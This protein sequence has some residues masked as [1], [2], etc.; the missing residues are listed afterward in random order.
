MKEL[1]PEYERELSISGA[2]PR[3]KVIFELVDGPFSG[4][5]SVEAGR[6]EL[7]INLLVSH[8]LLKHSSGF[9][10]KFL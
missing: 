8:D 10:V 3:Y 1:I 4:V 2:E 6:D 5:M 7:I 9:I